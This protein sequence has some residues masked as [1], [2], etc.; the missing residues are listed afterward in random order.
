MALVSLALELVACTLVADELLELSGEQ[1]TNARAARAVIAESV[2][3]DFISLFMVF[4]F[5]NCCQR[6]A[7]LPSLISRTKIREDPILC[8]GVKPYCEI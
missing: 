1:P 3:I 2:I 6:I 7:T 5:I 8:Y 4:T